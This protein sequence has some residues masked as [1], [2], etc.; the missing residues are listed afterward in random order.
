MNFND[1]TNFFHFQTTQEECKTVRKMDPPKKLELKTV[2]KLHNAPTV[3]V[4]KP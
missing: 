2:K 1:I 3:I 4:Q